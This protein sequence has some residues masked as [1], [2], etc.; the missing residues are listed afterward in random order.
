MLLGYYLHQQPPALPMF[1]AGD[2]SWVYP[3]SSGS[4]DVHLLAVALLGFVFAGVMAIFSRKLA[5]AAYGLNVLPVWL[6][7]ALVEL[8]GSLWAAAKLGFIS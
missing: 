8:D 2:S 7:W 4:D 5:M 6:A 1:Q 3:Q